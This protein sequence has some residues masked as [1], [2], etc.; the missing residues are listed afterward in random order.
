MVSNQPLR[1]DDL[2]EKQISEMIWEQ[3]EHLEECQLASEFSANQFAFL[4]ANRKDTALVT[5][6]LNGLLQHI[7]DEVE[8][9]YE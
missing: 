1:L 7:C 4:I 5:D 6:V 9:E 3:L 2:T 8:I